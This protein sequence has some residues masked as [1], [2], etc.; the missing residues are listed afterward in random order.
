MV[1]LRKKFVKLFLSFL[2]VFLISSV[3]YS[4]DKTRGSIYHEIYNPF[5]IMADTQSNHL[6]V[7]DENNPITTVESSY[8]DFKYE[9]YKNDDVLS[10]YASSYCLVGGQYDLSIWS[11]PRNSGL[12][13]YRGGLYYCQTTNDLINKVKLPASWS[14]DEL[15]LYC[16]DGKFINS[17]INN[18]DFLTNHVETYKLCVLRNLDRKKTIVY[19]LD[20]GNVLV[21]NEYAGFFKTDYGSIISQSSFDKLNEGT[22]KFKETGSPDFFQNVNFKFTYD[23]DLSL[24]TLTDSGEALDTSLKTIFPQ[25]IGLSRVALFRSQNGKKLY[26]YESVAKLVSGVNNVEDVILPVY[27]IKYGEFSAIDTM[28]CR[29]MLAYYEPSPTL[30]NIGDKV[31]CVNDGEVLINAIG[32]DGG[33]YGRPRII[34]EEDGTVL[35]SGDADSFSLFK[36]IIFDLNIGSQGVDS[37]TQLVVQTPNSGSSGSIPLIVINDLE[38]SSGYKLDIYKSSNKNAP[39]YFFIHGG[40]WSSGDKAEMD[41]VEM[42][43]DFVKAGVNVVS[44]NYVLAKNGDPNTQYPNSLKNVDCALR[45]FSAKA[46]EYGLNKNNFHL[47]GESAGGH[48]A[49]LYSL[50]RAAY[51]DETCPYP[52][53][54]PTIKEVISV[55]GATDLTSM[56]S[57]ETFIGKSLNS[58]NLASFRQASPITYVNSNNG[59][60]YNLIY[61]SASDVQVFYDKLESKG[62]NVNLDTNDNEDP[63]GFGRSDNDPNSK[64][65]NAIKR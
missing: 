40:D 11:Y 49:M 45:W 16:N 47:G 43:Y 42:A 3:V 10:T 28:K 6:M 26:G 63:E 24:Y 52:Q 61:D 25:D 58:A 29:N 8:I 57:A 27:K 18:F 7:S 5:E 32:I 59:I 19:G 39:T 9:E 62:F 65:L 12:Y 2:L 17:M 30:S 60:K 37:S 13:T 55:E 21:E 46:D 4:A 33:N 31:F 51:I 53:S 64:V 54:Y 36:N 22:Y 41:I 35:Q 50:N 56:L 23:S 14:A 38:Y 20:A 44:M 1:L 34:A 15:V 48:M